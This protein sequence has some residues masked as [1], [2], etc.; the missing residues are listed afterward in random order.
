MKTIIYQKTIKDAKVPTKATAKSKGYDLF[1]T[2][3]GAILPFESDVVDIGIKCHIPP[4]SYFFITSKSGLA[5]KNKVFVLNAPGLID[6]DYRDSLMV[7]LFNANK[8]ETFYYTKG[9]KLAQLISLPDGEYE[10]VEG[11]VEPHEERVGGLGSTG[12]H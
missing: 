12:T 11:I 4:G 6:E 8:T 5:A 3:N 1:A 9:Q 7:I 2:E 10:F